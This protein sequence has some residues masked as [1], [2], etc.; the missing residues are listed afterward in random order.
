MSNA[1]KLADNLPTEGQ[2]GNR[3]LI[4]NGKCSV[5]QRGDQT[6]ASTSTVSGPD[7]FFLY[8]SATS[9]QVDVSQEEDGPDGFETCFQWKTSAVRTG[10]TSDQ[11]TGFG[12]NFEIQDVIP[13]IWSGKSHVTA[14]FWVKSSIAG[15]FAFNINPDNTNSGGSGDRIL[16]HA[17]Y[18]VNAV[19]TWEYKTITIP[20]SFLDSYAL[21]SGYS[22]VA[23]G[24]EVTWIMDLSTGGSRD[25][26]VLGW[27]P[28][29][30]EARN[31][32]TSSAG[33]TT[34]FFSTLNATFK[35]TG[36]Q[37]EVG[38]QSTPF[39]HEPYET[40]L[41]KCERYF[42]VYAE[43]AYVPVAVGISTSSSQ[44]RVFLNYR[45]VMRA[46]PSLDYNNLIHTDRTNYNLDITGLSIPNG[47]EKGMV[48]NLASSSG[49][50]SNRVAFLTADVTGGNY[51]FHLDAEL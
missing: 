40:T 44:G 24:L 4:I 38:S 22:K 20:L 45:T 32:A 17:I 37:L 41:R 48:I 26:A 10:S 28:P 16:Y 2:L 29:A 42:Q 9:Y 3:N 6:N 30:T 36:I 49:A 35:I 15:D 51:R 1:R 25:D 46:T 13:Y 5:N 12:M 33:A 8:K 31:F 43:N 39:E 19:D 23:N 50:T 11:Y 34:G 7:R 27:N 47:D 14:S 21:S 18:T